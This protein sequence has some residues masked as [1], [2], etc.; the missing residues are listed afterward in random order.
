LPT[1]LRTAFL[2]YCPNCLFGKL[3]DGLLRPKPSCAVCGMPFELHGGTFTMTAFIL[4]ILICGF[5]VIE[6]AALALL[7]GFFPG[8]AWVLGASAAALYLALN[9]PV[10]GLWV[11]CLWR[12]GYLG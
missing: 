3:F 1:L 8:Y 2:G 6:G 4:Y 10:R 5:L 12:L 7:F 9:R 11:W